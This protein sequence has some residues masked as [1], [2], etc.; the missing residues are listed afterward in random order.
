[1]MW[2][3]T[4][5]LP[6]IRGGA[7]PVQLPCGP[8]MHGYRSQMAQNQMRVDLTVFA[9]GSIAVGGRHKDWE[10]PSHRRI[11]QSGRG[12]T[13]SRKESIHNQTS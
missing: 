3:L 8:D 12:G 4:S 13:K 10:T 6:V 1:M 2:M 7:S 11:L 5:F 9:L